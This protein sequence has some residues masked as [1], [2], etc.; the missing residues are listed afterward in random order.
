MPP[1]PMSR[2][3]FAV[4]NFL[5]SRFSDQSVGCQSLLI[6][7]VP[8]VLGEEVRVLANRGITLACFLFFHADFFQ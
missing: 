6:R 8:V 3:R 7:F 5:R 2:I 4:F 1:F